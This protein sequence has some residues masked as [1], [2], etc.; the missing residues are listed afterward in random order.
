MGEVVAQMAVKSENAI[1]QVL[2]QKSERKEFVRS[3][4]GSGYDEFWDNKNRYRVVLS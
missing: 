4:R 2:K 1:L 3:V